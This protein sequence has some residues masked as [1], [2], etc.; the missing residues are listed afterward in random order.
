M[1][2]DPKRKKGFKLSL[3][4]SQGRMK[5]MS[6]DFFGYFSGKN[7]EVIVVLSS[8]QTSLPFPR[9]DVTLKKDDL[10]ATFAVLGD[11]ES[12]QRMTPADASRALHI[13]INLHEGRVDLL[14]SADSL[15]R[16]TA[17][18]L[19]DLLGLRNYREFLDIGNDRQALTSRKSE[20]HILEGTGLEACQSR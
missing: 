2:L 16:E 15:Y 17:T 12:G 8:E 4:K 18:S 11:P 13:R 10:E 14:P 6:E 9:Y 7:I 19:R 20:R 3:S 1:S 5:P